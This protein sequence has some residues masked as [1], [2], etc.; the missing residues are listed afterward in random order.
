MDKL[1]GSG[2]RGVSRRAFLGGA[3]L[4][5]AGVLLAACGL[6]AGPTGESGDMQ[7]ADAPAKEDATAPMSEGAVAV[8][9]WQWGTTYV[10][11]FDTLVADYNQIQERSR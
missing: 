7:K 11:G 2:V 9:L 1:I 10:P 6:Q 3:T 8:L 4:S 5:G